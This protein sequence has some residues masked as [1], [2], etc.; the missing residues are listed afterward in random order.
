MTSNK[1][2]NTPS[3]RSSCNQ[4]PEFWQQLEKDFSFEGVDEALLR[5]HT[6]QWVACANELLGP[7]PSQIKNKTKR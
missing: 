4:D 1:F 3:C 7:L 5:L 6:E 2:A